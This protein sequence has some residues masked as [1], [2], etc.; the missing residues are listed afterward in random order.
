MRAPSLSEQREFWD[1]WNSQWRFGDVDAF[2]ARQA[3]VAAATCRRLGLAEARILEVGC[4]TGWLGATLTGFGAVTGVDLSPRSIDEGQQRYPSV[5]LICGDVLSVELSPPYDL[6]LSADSFAH[7]YDQ[8]RF[9]ERI[10]TLLAPRGTFLL[11]TQN[12]FV[13]DRRSKR[14]PLGRGQIQQ[15]PPLTEVKAAL[16][17]HFHMRHIGSIVPG[18]DRGLLWWVENRYVRGGLRR[19]GLLPGWE[20]ALERVRLGR[21]LVIEAERHDQ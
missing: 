2:M 21:E 11:M 8:R 12:A 4:G 14:A 19:V 13:W 5:E 9:V 18:G 16:S 1:G 17:A 3:E 7:V 10:S 20:R 6:V 15:W